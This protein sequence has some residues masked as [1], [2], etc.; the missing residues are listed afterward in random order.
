ML[1]H[2]RYKDAYLYTYKHGTSIVSERSPFAFWYA[3][4]RME[5]TRLFYCIKNPNSEDSSH[6]REKK[7]KQKSLERLDEQTRYDEL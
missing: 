6:I 5:D 7:R 4:M 3:T 2:Q 1:Q